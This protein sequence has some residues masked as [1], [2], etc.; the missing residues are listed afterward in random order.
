MLVQQEVESDSNSELVPESEYDPEPGTN[1]DLASED[2]EVDDELDYE[3]QDEDEQTDEE[4]YEE[5]MQ[6]DVSDVSLP[7]VKWKGKA[8][9]SNKKTLSNLLP[10]YL[11]F[12]MTP[13]GGD[14]WKEQAKDDAARVRNNHVLHI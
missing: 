1:S 8:P 11:Q 9:G 7:E 14:L 4:E 13:H 12:R 3:P 5:D 10:M 2:F 6:S